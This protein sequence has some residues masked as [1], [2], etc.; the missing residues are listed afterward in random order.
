MYVCLGKAWREVGSPGLSVEASGRQRQSAWASSRRNIQ[1]S[2][3]SS[4][5]SLCL[6]L[7][8]VFSH[9]DLFAAL[10]LALALLAFL[11]SRWNN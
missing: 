11:V 10:Q 7:A 1:G 8:P 4:I 6:S 9:V 2:P 5:R 3:G